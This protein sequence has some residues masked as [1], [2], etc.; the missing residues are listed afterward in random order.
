MPNYNYRSNDYMRRNQ[1]SRQIMH[2]T[3]V[4]TAQGYHIH[5]EERSSGTCMHD[6][7]NGLPIAMAYVPW[8]EF[9]DLYSAEKAFCR[10]TIFEELDKP[11]LGKGGCCK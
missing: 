6:P 8:Q 10:G 9:K 2:T 5:T 4:E 1:C 3:P 11:F 7:L